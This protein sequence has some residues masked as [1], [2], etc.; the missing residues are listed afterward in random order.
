MHH[1]LQ[2]NDGT[3]HKFRDRGQSN[4]QNSGNLAITKPLGAQV[5]TRL[6]LAGEVANCL[7]QMDRP[8]GIEKCFFRIAVGICLRLKP[9]SDFLFGGGGAVLQGAM[10]VQCEIRS[11]REKPRAQILN[12]MAPADCDIEFQ[13]GFLRQILR[14]HWIRPKGNQI[15]VDRLPIVPVRSAD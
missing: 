12:V 4:S 13:E 8:L 10:V 1:L 15:A 5:Q 9:R 11:H 14:F 3:P 6:L 7:L 2:A